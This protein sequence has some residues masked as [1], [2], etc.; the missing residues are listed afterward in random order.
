MSTKP[1]SVTLDAETEELIKR[2]GK[3][4]LLGDNKSAILRYAVR[5]TAKTL[6]GVE[7]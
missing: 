2:L 5:F 1:T 4:M 7:E 3:E 6:L